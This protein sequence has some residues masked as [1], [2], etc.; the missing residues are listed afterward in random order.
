M[1]AMVMMGLLIAV[2]VVGTAHHTCK[3][4]LMDKPQTLLTVLRFALLCFQPV[5]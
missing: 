2:L 4:L 1:D 3:Q 5:V